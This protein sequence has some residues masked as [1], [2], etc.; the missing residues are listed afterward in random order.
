MKLFVV[1][2]DELNKEFN[3]E[4]IG[5][6]SETMP[7]AKSILVV[8]SE[9]LIQF[10][11]NSITTKGWKLGLITRTKFYEEEETEFSGWIKRILIV[12]RD[13]NKNQKERSFIVSDTKHG[14]N[15]TDFEAGL[16]AKANLG[17]FLIRKYKK[18]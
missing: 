12:S 11:I 3:P 2:D 17:L 4:K 8:D 14:S 16:T 7:N 1:Q 13:L 9:N 18:D 5:L 6:V 10:S 15:L